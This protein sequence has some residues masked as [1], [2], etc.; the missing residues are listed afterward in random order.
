MRVSRPSAGP[1]KLTDGQLCEAAALHASGLPITQLATQYQTSHHNLRRWLKRGGF[2]VASNLE[3]GARRR[4]PCN[5]DFFE[6]I[7]TEE[8]AYWAGFITA[9]GCITRNINSPV[10]SI[11]VSSTDKNHLRAFLVALS[12]ALVLNQR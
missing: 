8:K 7:D 10:L 9:D 12:A 6:R 2:R 3:T 1:R 4:H 5:D 11:G